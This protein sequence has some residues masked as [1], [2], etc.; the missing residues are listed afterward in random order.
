MPV[1]ESWFGTLSGKYGTT[2]TYNY[3]DGQ[4]IHR[5]GDDFV[6]STLYNFTLNGNR[7]KYLQMVIC[8]FE[9]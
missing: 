8:Q 3:V 9:N 7:Q 5:K 6:D 2:I 1:E 4:S